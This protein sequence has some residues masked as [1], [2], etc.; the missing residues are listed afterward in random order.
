MLSRSLKADPEKGNR[1][2]E[3]PGDCCRE[4]DVGGVQRARVKNGVALATKVS[5]CLTGFVARWEASECLLGVIQQSYYHTYTMC[6]YTNVHMYIYTTSTHMST[7]ANRVLRMRVKK[8]QKTKP[9][10]GFFCSLIGL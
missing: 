6:I 9:H 3:L 1:R 8:Y 2:R 7:L 5:H 10:D 4:T